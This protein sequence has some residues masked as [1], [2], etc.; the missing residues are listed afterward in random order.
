MPA[1]CSRERLPF[2]LVGDQPRQSTSRPGSIL[3]CRGGNEST[4]SSNVEALGRCV[5]VPNGQ[6]G[7]QPGG[8]QHYGMS[9]AP[10]FITPREAVGGTTRGE[11]SLDSQGEGRSRRGRTGQVHS[12]N[13]RRRGRSTPGK[14]G[15]PK[16][17][18]PS[19]PAV[20]GASGEDISHKAIAEREMG[21][22]GIGAW[23]RSSVEGG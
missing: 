23:A 17:G 19:R 11:P 5:A 22:A 1:M 18:R 13:R 15:G 21:G 7:E 8:P 16:A 4:E 12:T 10:K 20:G 3:D 2:L 6:E 14:K 9:A